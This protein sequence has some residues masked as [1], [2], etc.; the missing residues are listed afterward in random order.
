M[1]LTLDWLD[2]TVSG[3]GHEHHRWN[4]KWRKRLNPLDGAGKGLA[5]QVKMGGL[6]T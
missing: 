4:Y 6:L 5:P 3:L 2:L 1:S